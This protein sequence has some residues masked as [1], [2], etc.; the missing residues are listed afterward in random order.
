MNPSYAP[1]RAVIIDDEAWI[2]EGLSEHIDWK[3]IGIELAGNYEDGCEAIAELKKRPAD[4]IMTDIRMPNMTGLELMAEL[5]NIERESE[6]ARRSQ[7]IIM[8]GFDD[9][10]YAQEA[11]R[12]GAFD[13]LLKPTDVEEIEQ[14]LLRAKASVDSARE[15][16]PRT[17]A[18]APDRDG[19][20]EEAS[21]LV[22]KATAIVNERFTEDLHLAQIAEQLFVTPNYLSRIF[23]AETGKSF[24]D[25]LSAK[26]AE[27]A[28]ELL[29][30][31]PL[32]IYQV[33]E[34]VGYPN[35]RYFSEWFQKQTGQ[36]PGDY[37]KYRS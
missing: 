26:R 35:P 33:G 31:S 4:I 8:S 11:L 2:R 37:R 34:A 25:H 30:A 6:D 13:Y 1:C 15:P 32:K 16:D 22:R 7:F 3:K 29:R 28:C 36:S 10:K 9:F 23:K 19:I 18:T 17:E 5:R 24:S 21:Y 27:R 12:L 20:A 14:V